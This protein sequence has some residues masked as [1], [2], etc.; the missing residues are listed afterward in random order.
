M[1][2]FGSVPGDALDRLRAAHRTRG[3]GG[4]WDQR[5]QSLRDMAARRYVPPFLFAYVYA[6]LGERDRAFEYLERAYQVSSGMIVF[7]GVHP[8]FSRLRDDPRFDALLARMGLPR[9]HSARLDTQPSEVRRGG[10]SDPP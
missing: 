5:V 4:Y 1:S 3:S 2:T 10:S 7:L 6:M 9:P 8:A